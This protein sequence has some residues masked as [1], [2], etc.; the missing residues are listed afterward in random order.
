MKTCTKCQKKKPLDDFNNLKKS[1]DGKAPICK[2]CK[3]EYDNNQ[4]ATN[5]KRRDAIKQANTD[6]IKEGMDYVRSYLSK[7]PCVDCGLKDPD[8]L[9]FDHVK[10]GKVAGVGR[11]VQTGNTLSTIKREID[12]CEVRCLHCHRKR[13]I[14]SLGWYSRFK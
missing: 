1:K 10:G 8:L 6:R 3:R 9:E 5:D 7:H 2:I 13:T 11:L 14:K 12:K 4:Y